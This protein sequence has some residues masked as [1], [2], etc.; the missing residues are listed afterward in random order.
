M[1][2]TDEQLDK[3]I[4]LFKQE[5]GKTIDRAEAQRQAVALITLVKRIYR[6]MTEEVFGQVVAKMIES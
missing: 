1:K 4:I 3:F 2:F 6:P 5:F